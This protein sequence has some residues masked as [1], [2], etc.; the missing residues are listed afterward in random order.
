MSKLD[1]LIEQIDDPGLRDKI[2]KEARTVEKR[3]RFGLVFEE[4]LPECTPLYDVP[5][6]VGSI[7]ARR[8]DDASDNYMVTDIHDGFAVCTKI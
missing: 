2:M 5:I 7:V 3:R 8:L 6:K 4:H 1:D